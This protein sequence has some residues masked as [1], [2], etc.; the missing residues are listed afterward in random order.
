MK[1]SYS[2][3]PKVDFSPIAAY[4]EILFYS[5]HT[6]A[7]RYESAS[8]HP[9]N[10]SM[11]KSCYYSNDTSTITNQLHYCQLLLQNINQYHLAIRIQNSTALCYKANLVYIRFS[12]GTF[13][14]FKHWKLETLCRNTL[15]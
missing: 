7:L 15:L 8:Y 4:S 1:H 14:P 3:N 11:R 12:F 5:S 2:Y 13:N 6:A 10:K 9:H